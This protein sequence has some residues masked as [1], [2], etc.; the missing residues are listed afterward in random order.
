MRHGL[1]TAPHAPAGQLNLAGA[2]HAVNLTIDAAGLAGTGG[3]PLDGSAASVVTFP[4]AETSAAALF[5][6]VTFP[7]SVTA[8]HM[9]AG[10]RLALR[11]TADMPGD[12]RAQ[13]SLAYEGPG[14]GAL[15]RAVKASG[16]ASVPR[17]LRMVVRPASGQRSS[18]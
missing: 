6:T 18:G 15:Q 3:P 13:G 14:R 1:R 12:P 11:A 16:G 2:G 5:A 7:P 10:R 9:P 17:P 8:T 4:P